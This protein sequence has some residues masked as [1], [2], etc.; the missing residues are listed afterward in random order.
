MRW[1]GYCRLQETNW[2]PKQHYYKINWLNR[3]HKNKIGSATG[4]ITVQK[5]SFSYKHMNKED[6]TQETKKW[7]R[8]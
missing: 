6:T 1:K 4:K 2:D 3:N 5:N 8:R 7:K